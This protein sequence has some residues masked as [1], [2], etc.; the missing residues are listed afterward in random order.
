VS[1]ARD[2]A[3]ALRGRDADTG[4]DVWILEYR[5]TE[6][7]TLMRGTDNKDVFAHGRYWVDAGDGRILRSEVVFNAL[8]TESSVT[9]SFERDERLGTSVPVRMQFKRGTAKSEVRGVATYG[10]FRRFEV[11]TEEVIQKRE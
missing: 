7:P 10:R 8:G 4:P 5:E 2:S 1:I 9:T 11:G 3:S 6:R